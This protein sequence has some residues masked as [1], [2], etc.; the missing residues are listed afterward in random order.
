M[1]KTVDDR[2]EHILTPSRI[3][4]LFHNLGGSAL[5]LDLTNQVT[6]E[7]KVKKR[8]KKGAIN[9]SPFCVA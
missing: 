1:V 6:L 8:K 9:F 5:A 7:N 2:L 4:I 3:K